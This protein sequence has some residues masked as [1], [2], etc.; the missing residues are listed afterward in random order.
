MQGNDKQNPY[1]RDQ[2][3]ED[4]SRDRWQKGSSNRP[5][6]RPSQ[7]NRRPAQ[8]ERYRAVHRPSSTG[9]GGRY[10]YGSDPRP[11]YERPYY[12]DYYPADDMSSAPYEGPER[13]LKRLG[14]AP[15]PRDPNIP[16]GMNQCEICGALVPRSRLEEHRSQRHA[17]PAEAGAQA[18]TEMKHCPH[19]SA[20]VRADRLE[21][22]IQKVH[23]DQ[24]I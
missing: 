7:D 14:E 13:T 18:K 23:S 20:P 22:H 6:G 2:F 4:Q 10:R 12:N 9:L 19:C 21:K 3:E 8:T 15:P 5:A 16:Q 11:D 24:D 1:R 17:G